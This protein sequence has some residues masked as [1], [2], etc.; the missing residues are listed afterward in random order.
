MSSL[1]PCYTYWDHEDLVCQITLWEMSLKSPESFIL[2]IHDPVPFKH[3]SLHISKPVHP[4]ALSC[5]FFN[6]PIHSGHSLYASCI[7]C[8]FS[9]IHLLW[10]L[11]YRITPPPPKDEFLEG[12]LLSCL[13]T[14]FLSQCLALSRFL[15]S[16]FWMSSYLNKGFLSQNICLLVLTL[17]DT[18]AQILVFRKRQGNKFSESIIFSFIIF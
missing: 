7:S 4:H 16:V 14:G 17:P 8:H 10:Q 11:F 9:A 13:P 5:D 6:V 15:F 1:F 18:I 2:G 12:R 3:T